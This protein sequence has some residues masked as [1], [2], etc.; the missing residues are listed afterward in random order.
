MFWQGRCYGLALRYC[1]SGFIVSVTVVKSAGVE[2]TDVPVDESTPNSVV[3]GE[4][5]SMP[6]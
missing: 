6:E 2:G 1:F 3:N 5:Q 4:V